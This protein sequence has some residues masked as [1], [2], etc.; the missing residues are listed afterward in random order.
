[1]I[2][3]KSQ[4]ERLLRDSF[5]FRVPSLITFAWNAVMEIVRFKQA[6][7]ELEVIICNY[8]LYKQANISVE[9]NTH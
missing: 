4:V 3:T 9:A 2:V 5:Q 7:N 1:M 6:K 8:N